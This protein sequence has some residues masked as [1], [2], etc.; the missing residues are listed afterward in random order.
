V[1]DE[2]LK[3]EIERIKNNIKNTDRVYL[4]RDLRLHLRDLKRDLKGFKQK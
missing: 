1:T 3:A 2:E 4:Q